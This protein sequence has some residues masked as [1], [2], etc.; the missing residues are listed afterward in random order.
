M[1][2]CLFLGWIGSVTAAVGKVTALGYMSCGGPE[3]E[4]QFKELCEGRSQRALPVSRELEEGDVTVSYHTGKE[5][6]K[7]YKCVC[8]FLSYTVNL[9][10]FC[11]ILHVNLSVKYHK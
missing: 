11:Y 5:L 9:T 8:V 3:Q 7:F 1:C 2:L 10:L 4:W 6:V